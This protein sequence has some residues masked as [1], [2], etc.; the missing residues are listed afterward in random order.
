MSGFELLL[1][2]RAVKLKAYNYIH[3][4]QPSR[5]LM[6]NRRLQKNAYSKHS[7]NVTHFQ[8]QNRIHTIVS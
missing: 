7:Q 3:V 5:I 6:S 2:S 4:P 8:Y 1:I